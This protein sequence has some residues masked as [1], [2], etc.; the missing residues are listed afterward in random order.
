[1]SI[2]TRT[3]TNDEVKRVFREKYILDGTVESVEPIDGGG[4]VI[5]IDDSVMPYA[6]NNPRPGC[7][8]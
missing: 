2:L 8:D 7:R 6:G 1:M 5:K 3:L 4:L